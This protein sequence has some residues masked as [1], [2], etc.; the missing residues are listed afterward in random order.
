M[1]ANRAILTLH[2]FT[3]SISKDQDGNT[4]LELLLPE[5][6]YPA[7]PLPPSH[8]YLATNYP[9]QYDLRLTSE[10]EGARV[11]NLYAFRE[12]LEGGDEDDEDDYDEEAFV[13]SDGEGDVKAKLK[14]IEKGQ[15]SRRRFHTQVIL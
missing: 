12:R 14:A 8:P 5:H 6:P 2:R 4:K 10:Q 3:S 13:N 9:R 15:K 11:R 7:I 1:E